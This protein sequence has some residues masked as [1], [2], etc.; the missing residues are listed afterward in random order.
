MFLPR[1]KVKNQR[2]RAQRKAGA[3]S[4]FENDVK[5][6]ERMKRCIC[7]CVCVCVRVCVHRRSDEP[8]CLSPTYC[9]IRARCHSDR[10]LH[11]L[12]LSPAQQDA[13]NLPSPPAT[14][15]KKKKDGTHTQTTAPASL[16]GG[17]E[18][19]SHGIK[20]RK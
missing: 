8:N 11:L 20:R 10:Q 18:E 19:T 4:V 12:S 6:S 1:L 16:D 3:V 13:A 15:E 9:F 7:V 17:T 14:H 5:V 2:S